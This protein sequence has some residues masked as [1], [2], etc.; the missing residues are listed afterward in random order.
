VV[1]VPLEAQEHDDF[2]ARAIPL[3]I[4][5][6]RTTTVPASVTLAQAIFET[7]RGKF[8]VGEALNYFG[9]KAGSAESDTL[10]LGPIATGWVWAWTKEWEDGRYVEKRE[11][12]RTY[13]SIEDS[14]R[15]HGLLLAT[16]PRY[17]EA[18]R[19]VDDPREFARRIAAAGYATSPTYAEDLIRVMD[20]ENLYR[21]DL[22]RN[23]ATEVSKSEPVQVQAGEIFQV[24]FDVKNMGFGTWSPEAGYALVSANS[25]RFGA[26]A[27]QNV[28]QMVRPEAVQRWAITMIAPDHA[29]TYSTIWRLK[30]GE[31]NFGPALRA[32]IQVAAKPSNPN[33]LWGGGAAAVVLSVGILVVARRGRGKRRTLRKTRG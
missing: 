7:G 28:A 4:S 5:S 22:S 31:K 1:A 30:H 11:K 26:A 19:A 3:A 18:M 27:R 17:A 25:N 10:V 33:Y 24:F 29:G 21:Y 6:Q 13:A 32:Q 9:I 23:D 2:L 14:F 15:D 8:P 12:F 16:A 20:R